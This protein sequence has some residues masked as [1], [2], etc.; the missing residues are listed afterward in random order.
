MLKICIFMHQEKKSLNLIVF[1]LYNYIYY[2]YP[3]STTKSLN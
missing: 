2:I 3:H 1:V